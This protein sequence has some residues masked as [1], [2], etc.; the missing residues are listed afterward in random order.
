MSSLE[1]WLNIMLGLTNPKK[2]Y[3]IYY[4]LNYNINLSTNIN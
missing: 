3:M 2:I 4:D 1:V